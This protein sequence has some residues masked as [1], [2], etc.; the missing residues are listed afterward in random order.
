MALRGPPCPRR[1]PA[2]PKKLTAAAEA[3]ASG[4]AL[5]PILPDCADAVRVFLL[6]DTQ[7]RTAGLGGV[8]GLD[9]AAVR[10]VTEALGIAWTEELLDRLQLL[11]TVAARALQRKAE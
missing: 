6:S 4:A 8:L 7:W 10:T 1:R 9:Y 5:P 3:W 11:E 2:R